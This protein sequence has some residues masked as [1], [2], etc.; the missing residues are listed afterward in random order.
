MN[1]SI[2][3]KDFLKSD[4]YIDL[5]QDTKTMYL[6][7]LICPD[8]GYLDVFK[9][10]KHLAVLITGM[11]VNSLEAGLEE[12]QKR[13]FIDMYNGYV[14]LL[15]KHTSSIGG[16]YGGVNRDRELANLPVD[17]RDHFGLDNLDIIEKESVKKLPK[18]PGPAPETIKE[19]ISKQPEALRATLQDFVD[20]R[21]ERKKAPTT[22]AVKGWINKLQQMYPDN[23]VKQ[24]LSL[25]QSIDR[26]WMG[27]FEV[28]ESEEEKKF[29]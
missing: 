2:I 11:S 28:K 5:H 22:R 13:G 14:G 8:K 18:K 29:M 6:Y 17:V 15:L 26:G 24:A 1:T 4:N 27:L 20:D 10:E 23:Y 9:L 21:I 16:Q 3:K 7:L 19:I 12:L 25:Q